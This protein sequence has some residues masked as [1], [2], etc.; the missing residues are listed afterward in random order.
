MM[1]N[2]VGIPGISNSDKLHLFAK[3]KHNPGSINRI[4]RPSPSQTLSHLTNILVTNWRVIPP[5]KHLVL[6]SSS[7]AHEKAITRSRI[8][9]LFPT[10]SCVSLTT[11][12]GGDASE[13]VG[14]FRPKPYTCDRPVG[15]RHLQYASPEKLRVGKRGSGV[16]A[17][18]LRERKMLL[19]NGQMN[20]C[21]PKLSYG[22]TAE[23]R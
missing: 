19:R 7:Q 20:L 8:V 22:P 4:L 10:G 6:K 12:S 5:P 16:G 11:F 23:Y 14:Q 18:T 3:Y 17:G 21:G 9:V 1:V 2:F 15:G 13:K